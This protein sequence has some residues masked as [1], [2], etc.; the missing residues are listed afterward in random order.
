MHAS[1]AGFRH[2]ETAPIDPPGSL[3]W[4]PLTAGR[5]ML[6]DP[7]GRL[8]ADWR[9]YGDVVRL[10]IGPIAY[11]GLSHPDHLQ[12]V[13]QENNRNYV[14]GPI[15]ARTRILIGDGLF[16]SEGDFW[17]RQRRLA[18]PAFHRQR[19]GGFGAT[20][21][22]TA[23]E[24][25]DAWSGAAATGEAFDLAAEMNR[26]T[27]RIVG[28]TLFSL[29]LQESAAAVGRALTD[30]LDIVTQRFF[31][32]LPL[33]LWVPTS[34]NRRFVRARR[35]L[36][37]AVLRIVGERRGA[38]RQHGDLLAMLLE[39]RDPDSGE[40]MTDRQLRDEVM[41]FVLA[42]HETTAVALAWTW[43]LLGRHPEVEQRLR[44]EVADAVGRRTPTPADLPALR[45][46]RMVVD[47]TLRLYPPVWAFGR[48]AV[49]D[50][51][52]GPF[53]IRAGAPVN[54]AVW[55]THRHPDFWPDAERFDPERFA[56]DRAATR[57]RFAYL[58]FSG[59]PRLCIGNEF[60][61]LEL[62]LVV[63]MMAQRYRIA[64]VDPDRVIEPLVRVTLRPQGG[65]PVRIRHA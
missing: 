12:H 6:R 50:D 55:L 25:L 39:A 3:L 15:I 47:E 20:M 61:L 48:Q 14:K 22:D 62:V 38:G 40:G 57:H 19:I 53:R 49:A 33:P 35:A 27:L 8:A 21:T 58:P 17:R 24:M 5:D 7:L 10:R 60:A 64:P 63:T 44:D 31:T 28:R 52:I 18:Q 45:Y 54:L 42:G 37:E 56:P 11:Y 16:T 1:E 9:A 26:L 43:Y 41:T 4:N 51:R 23:G 29:D 65:V 46:V 2:L 36:D 30:A 13:L 34:P 59:G 32:L